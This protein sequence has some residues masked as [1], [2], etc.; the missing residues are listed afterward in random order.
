MEREIPYNKKKGLLSFDKRPSRLE[1][2]G[3]GFEPTHGAISHST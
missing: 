2:V 3:G 1:A